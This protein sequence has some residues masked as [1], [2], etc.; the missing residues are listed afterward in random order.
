[1]TVPSCLLYTQAAEA[2]RNA[3]A[4]WRKQLNDQMW[5]LGS[6]LAVQGTDQAPPPLLA[7]GQAAAGPEDGLAEWLA[8]GG[9]APALSSA[10]PLHPPLPHGLL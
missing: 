5:S 4:T 6:K 1:M 8:H 2:L 9:A 3:K 7:S 10:P